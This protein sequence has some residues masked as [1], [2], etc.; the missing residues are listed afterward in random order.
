M[1]SEASCG[2]L[3]IEVWGQT[4]LIGSGTGSILLCCL[5]VYPNGRSIGIFDLHSVS[6]LDL[7]CCQ[8]YEELVAFICIFLIF[9]ILGNHPDTYFY[10]VRKNS[11]DSLQE[12]MRSNHTNKIF[13]KHVIL[14]LP[15]E[16]SGVMVQVSYVSS[17]CLCLCQRGAIWSTRCFPS[18]VSCYDELWLSLIKPLLF[19]GIKTFGNRCPFHLGFVAI[20]VPHVSFIFRGYYITIL[21]ELRFLKTESISLAVWRSSLKTNE[22]SLMT[23]VWIYCKI[24][25]TYQN[26]VQRW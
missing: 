2:Y 25:E 3:C 1:L 20:L 17:K 15:P 10:P 7:Q 6:W 21:S 11:R 19:F 23:L 18:A 22:A 9:C 16:H 8:H 5:C 12:I 26:P 14:V 4:T 13:K 24:S